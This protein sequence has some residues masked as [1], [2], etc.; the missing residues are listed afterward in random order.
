[1]MASELRTETTMKANQRRRAA[2]AN[3]SPSLRV[4]ACICR[5][6]C[7]DEQH[8]RTKVPL[9]PPCLHVVG[10]RNGGGASDGQ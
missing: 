6:W 10:V 7:S 9:L 5:L 2:P 3:Q 8:R 4:A 1:M